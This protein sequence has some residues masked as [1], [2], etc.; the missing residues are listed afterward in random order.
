MYRFLRNTHLV[1]GLFGCLYVLVYGVSSIRFSHRNWFPITTTS[2]VS[3]VTIPGEAGGSARSVA[4]ELMDKHGLSGDLIGGKVT[5]EGFEFQLVKAGIRYGVEYTKSTGEAL[6]TARKPDF[7]SMLVSLHVEHGL[8]HE[9]PV[10][11]A[12]GILVGIVSVALVIL[13]LT[14]IYLWFKLHEERKMGI[15]LLVLSVSYSLTAM[16]LLGIA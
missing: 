8:W 13:A 5:P 14:G 2:R 11:E 1:L 10:R 4:R 7:M 16:V 9:D 6:I 15:V 12:L 3:K